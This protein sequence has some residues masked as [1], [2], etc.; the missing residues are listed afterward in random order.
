M[1]QPPVY[2]AHR[3]LSIHC[4]QYTSCILTSLRRVRSLRVRSRALRTFANRALVILLHLEVVSVWFLLLNNRLQRLN[5]F[6]LSG[7]RP[8]PDE[9]DPEFG[10]QQEPPKKKRRRQALSCTGKTLLI[11]RCVLEM[12]MS[13]DR[14]FIR[15]FS[16]WPP[17]TYGYRGFRC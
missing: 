2:K 17:F 15:V 4:L 5:R 9:S 7:S 13:D 8:A 12:I 14:T 11:T 16:S 3:S 10:D 6:S 1:Y